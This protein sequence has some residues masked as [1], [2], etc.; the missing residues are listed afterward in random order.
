MP[1]TLQPLVWVC[2]PW[3]S[4]NSNISA[5]FSGFF[6]HMPCTICQSRRSRG[7]FVLEM[8][9]DHDLGGTAR[10]GAIMCD[11]RQW[12]ATHAPLGLLAQALETVVSQRDGSASREITEIRWASEISPTTTISLDRGVDL[13]MH[14][15]L[16]SAMRCNSL[17]NS[18]FVGPI[19]CNRQRFVRTP[20]GVGGRHMLRDRSHRVDDAKRAVGQPWERGALQGRTVT[21]L[22]SMEGPLALVMLRHVRQVAQ[23]ERHR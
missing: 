7:F 23:R 16:G 22:G 5:A 2:S 13:C 20:Q 18:L 1:H 10:V 9:A 15:L 21:A 11:C 19:T 17:H 8:D 14:R 12:R 3:V 4:I 6:P